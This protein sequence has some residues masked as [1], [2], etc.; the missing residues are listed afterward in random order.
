MK[1]TTHPT[2]DRELATIIGL[3]VLLFFIAMLCLRHLA[4]VEITG[5]LSN[6]LF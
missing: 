3:A 6:G 4:N 5:D 2:L 1:N